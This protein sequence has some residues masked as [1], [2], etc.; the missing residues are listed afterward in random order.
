MAEP[1]TRSAPVPL[2]SW[3]AVGLPLGLFAWLC[4][5]VPEVSAG[6][7]RHWEVQWLPQHDI[8]LSFFVDGLSLLFALLITGIGTLIFLYA[9]E[10]MRGAPHIGRFT[11][12]LT[13]FMLS[14][15]GIVLSE[16][17]ITL[18]IAWELTGVTSF[19]LI[20]YRHE[21]ATSR[22]SAWQALMVTGAG[23][24]AMLAGFVL[25]GEAAG[26]YSLR[27][28]LA[29]R[30]ALAADHRYHWILALV[31]AGAFT[32]SAQFPFHFWLPNAMAAPTPVSAYLH[33]ATMVKAGV[34][35][36]ARM[37]PVLG[38]TEAWTA[39]LVTVGAITT[40]HSAV[41][42]LTR[43]DL[44][45][46][47]A[48]TTVMALGACVLFLGVPTQ[49]IEGD[50]SAAA[51]AAMCL[52]LVHALYK[53]ALFMAA[54]A[55]EHS[56]GTRDLRLLGGIGKRMRWISAGIV[57][58]CLSMAG[59]PPTIG[60]V[61]KEALYSSASAAP[62]GTVALVAIFLASA[63]IGTV[64]LVLAGPLLWG[65]LTEAAARAKPAPWQLWCGPAILGAAGI[66]AGLAAGPTFG[67]L[68]LPAAASVGELPEHFVPSLWHGL[69]PALLLSM[70]TWGLAALVFWKRRAVARVVSSS[71]S[72]IP[73]TGDSAYD[74]VM[75][76]IAASA[77][78]LTAVLQSG[79]H[80]RY[81]ATV[82]ASLAL[83]LAT[84]LVV[85]DAIHVP[86]LVPEASF[87]EWMLGGLIAAS[88]LTVIFTRSRLL[89]IGSIG[90]VGT[91]A[92]LIFLLFGAPDV[93]MAQLMVETLV[94]V[95][96]AIVLL[97]LPSFHYE[98]RQNR[99][100]R[101]RDAVV[102]TAVGA[103]TSLVVLAVI[104][105]PPQRSLTEYFERTA[106]PGGHGRNIVNVI[107]VEFR[108]LDTLGEITVLFLAGSAVC[109]L[110]QR[111]SRY[112]RLGSLVAAGKASATATDPELSQR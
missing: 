20:G 63:L 15:L 4:S 38:G 92:S 40:V 107:L 16:D 64:A 2:Y 26:T 62:S 11:V 86:E 3:A 54:G 51:A 41:V 96:V 106:V 110:I 100:R 65:R 112:R 48:Y 99:F 21:D 104:T 82:F 85:R 49:T 73:L 94:V 34:F 37:A 13:A 81:V 102:A 28:I 70:A 19:L 56:T 87:F 45:Q 23:G 61:G 35:L 24:L 101:F 76:G 66:V 42:A 77:L 80:R 31:L 57:L 53:A 7:S 22:R 83:V 88:A 29:D 71:L 43:R 18:F 58:A 47:L 30:G 78:G 105:D 50:V 74:K 109:A 72:I 103:A 93:A 46:V 39:T 36:L 27:E 60:F 67:A 25:L 89:A 17:L 95:I 12:F 69:G 59:L 111:R 5:F 33:S 14:M 79:V 84:T 90:V 68:V 6:E 10:Y 75:H 8:A 55:I 97:R 108:A 44:K 98:I 52:V 9:A 91:A 32:K 1:A